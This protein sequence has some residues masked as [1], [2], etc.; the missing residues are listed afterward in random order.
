MLQAAIFGAGWILSH[1]D[2]QFPFGRPK[3]CLLW[4]EAV[5]KATAKTSRSRLMR[6]C[7]STYMLTAV[8]GFND[9][10][11]NQLS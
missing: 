9:T 11:V 7:G 6:L 4:K 8:I 1:V 3:V 10:Y 2:F 5:R